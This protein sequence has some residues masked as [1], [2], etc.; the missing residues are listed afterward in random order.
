MERKADIVSDEL[1]KWINHW[2]SFRLTQCHPRIL[3]WQGE[4]KTGENLKTSIYGQLARLGDEEIQRKFAAACPVEGASPGEYG[5]RF[6]ELEGVGSLL[7]GIHFYGG[8]LARPFVHVSAFDF[9]LNADRANQLQSLIRRE[10]SVFRPVQFRIWLD[11]EDSPAA[12][13]PGAELDQWFLVGALS[14]IQKSGLPANSSRISL[15]ADPELDSYSAFEKCYRDFL[16]EDPGMEAWL[17]PAD[18]KLMKASAKEGKNYRVHIEGE[19]AGWIAGKRD[20]AGPLSGWQISDEL[21][22]S[23][24]RGQGFAPAMQRA[25]LDTLPAE[26]LIWGTIDVRNA[27]SLAT[28]RRVGREIVCGYLF[29]PL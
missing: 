19:P 4:E 23:R 11:S 17:A 22:E 7:A 29:L 1:E 8:N 14:D 25:F 26:D 3:E 13:I 9:E 15:V 10:F 28:A 20:D 21:L 27:A 2:L 24:F 18:R 6:L 12:G 5:I 16:A